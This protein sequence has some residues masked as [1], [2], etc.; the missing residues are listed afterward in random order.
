MSTSLEEYVRKSMETI[1]NRDQLEKMRLEVSKKFKLSRVVSNTDI[2]LMLRNEERQRYSELLTRKPTRTM[3][4]VSVI[5]VMT[6][7]FSCP[8]GRCTYC[9]GGV[10]F[11]SPQS[12]TGFEPAAMRGRQNN[13]DSYLQTKN[14]LEQLKRIGHPTDK[15]DLIVMGGTFT[16]R[17]EDYQRAF[18]KGSIDAMNGFVSRDLRTSILENESA[19][20]RC[21]GLT[22]ETRPDWFFEKELDLAL[23]YGTTK[24]ELG[25]Q[26][27]FNDI[28]RDTRRAH[29]ISDVIRSTRTAKDAAFKIL[30]HLMPGIGGIDEAADVKSLRRLFDDERLRPDMLKIYPA[31]VVEGTQYYE[32]FKRGEYRSYES[33]EAVEVVSEYFK[34]IPNY[35][36]IH[37]IQR[38]IP[39]YKI[40]Q[41]VKRSDLH[42]LALK[43]AL[44]KG[45]DIK[46]IRYRE[47]GH[48]HKVTGKIEMKITNYFA[49]RGTEKFLEFVDE[50]DKIIAFLRLRIPGE[51]GGR[52]ELMGRSLVREIKTFGKE[53]RIDEEGEFQHQGYGRRLLRE[54]EDITREMGL[55]GIAVI[56]GIGVREYFRK[57][58]YERLGPYMSKNT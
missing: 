27:V 13:Y 51:N 22:V 30:Y 28:H 38:D 1:S 49:S 12:Y 31:L 23:D 43:R 18:V 36:R 56:S 40:V 42:D 53:A 32:A 6:S 29:R 25:V 14:R 19:K 44:E 34:H 15:I 10:D 24:V 20:N 54:A 33:D 3:S 37:R 45:Y 2:L 58:G 9:P 46:E 47:I 57:N 8:H 52:N 21:I 5:A 11:S 35:V 16:A 55:P 17:N 39:V 50:E 48:S 26:T 4:G 7:P 41:G